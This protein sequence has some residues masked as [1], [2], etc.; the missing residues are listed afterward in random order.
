MRNE[1]SRSFDLLAEVACVKAVAL[2]GLLAPPLLHD[3]DIFSLQVSGAK[4]SSQFTRS[5]K[6]PL[7]SRLDALR[8]CPLALS[9]IVVHLPMLPG[10]AG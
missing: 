4:G 2:V 9:L 7:K 10:A 5:S 8:H 1:W 3:G 6:F